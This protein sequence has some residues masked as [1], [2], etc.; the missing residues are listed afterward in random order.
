[1]NARLDENLGNLV[2]MEQIP[3]T[4]KEKKYPKIVLDQGLLLT[5]E[6][7]LTPFKEFGKSYFWQQDVALMFEEQLVDPGLECP[8]KMCLLILAWI[9]KARL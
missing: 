3:Y 5:E 6:M 4:P 2:Y 8:E 1:M 7:L 9:V